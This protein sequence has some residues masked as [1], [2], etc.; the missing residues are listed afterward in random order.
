MCG[1]HGFNG[2]DACCPPAQIFQE[3]ICGNFNGA[4]SDTDIIVWTAPTVFND[5]IQGTFEIFNSA[6]STGAVGGSVSNSVGGPVTFT[7]DPGNSISSS[8]ISPTSFTITAGAGE[9]GTYCI[10]LYKRVLA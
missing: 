2:G 4:S 5:Y 3:K 6:R 8:V 9:T 7:A 1:S 10:T